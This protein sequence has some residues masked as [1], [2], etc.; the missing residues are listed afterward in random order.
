[1][2]RRTPPLAAALSLGLLLASRAVH[3]QPAATDDASTRFKR[4]VELYEERD[5]RA[6]ILEFQ[7]AYEIKPNFRVLYNIG[8]AYMELQD[9]VAAFDTLSRYLVEGGAEVPQERVAE[10]KAEIEKAKSRIARVE[11]ATSVEGATVL[12]DD[13]EVGTTPLKEPVRVSAGQRRVTLSKTGHV[14]TTRSIAIAGGDSAKLALDLA[15]I[16]VNKPPASEGAARLPGTP[17]WVLLATTGAFGIGAGVAGGLAVAQ[18]SSHDEL[19]ETQGAAL[20]DIQVSAS[21]L[22]QRTIATDVLLGATGVSAV[23]T[24][25][26]A[27]TTTSQPPAGKAQGHVRPLIGPTFAGLEGSF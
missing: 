25:V 10:V 14:P 15:P 12:I 3:A 20:D 2:I 8:M 22:K 19:L 27:F 17:F 24:V 13:V 23:L 4:G 7:R 16:G 1:M 9:Y 11:I 18:K 5:F 21:E 26:L 6:S